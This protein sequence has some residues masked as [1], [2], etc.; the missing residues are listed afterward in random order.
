MTS[1][2]TT[3]IR[4]GIP[5]NGFTP[6]ASARVCPPLVHEVADVPSLQQVPPTE[7]L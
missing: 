1:Y 2:R 7:R 5:T 6:F 4:T 3:S